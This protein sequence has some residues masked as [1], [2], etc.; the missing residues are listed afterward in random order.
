M[1][2]IAQIIGFPYLLDIAVP[3]L[4]ILLTIYTKCVARND[5]LVPARR[6]DFA[7]GLDLAILSVVSFVVSTTVNWRH[8]AQPGAGAEALEKVAGAPWIILAMMVAVWGLST[9][10]R[11]CGWDEN[12]QL[13]WGWGVVVPNALGFGMLLFTVEWGHVA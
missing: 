6:E 7:V 12:G 9:L 4:A 11:K 10:V 1:G 13:R 8:A 3:M 2:S 5:N